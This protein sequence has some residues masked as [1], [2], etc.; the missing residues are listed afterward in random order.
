MIKLEKITD[1]N[2]AFDM[3]HGTSK[4]GNLFNTK[5]VD[6]IEAFGQPTFDQESGDGKVN[7]EWVFDFNGDTFTIY[8][9][10]TWDAEY[11]KNELTSWSIGS[12]VYYG[13]FSDCVESILRIKSKKIQDA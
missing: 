12:R 4:S 5:Y 10:K 9:W 7:F 13:D 8:D 2:Q 1:K 11:T 3:M 6:L